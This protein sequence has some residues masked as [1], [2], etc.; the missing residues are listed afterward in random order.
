[1]NIFSPPMPR[2]PGQASARNK[3][4]LVYDNELPIDKSVFRYRLWLSRNKP[5]VLVVTGVSGQPPSWQSTRIAQRVYNSHIKSAMR[6]TSAP[7]HY[8]EVFRSGGEVY[9][10]SVIFEAS[11]D[12]SGVACFWNP[13]AKAIDMQS[14]EELVGGPVDLGSFS[15]SGDWV[16]SEL[17]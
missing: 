16:M 13:M 1:M 5:A 15:E 3:M 10:H 9:I 7:F 6:S 8:I 17:R 11:C 12:K 2:S 4:H 14:L